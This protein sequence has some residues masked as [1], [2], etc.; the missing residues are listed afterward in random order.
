[1]CF[2]HKEGE[3]SRVCKLP[4]KV[5]TLEKGTIAEGMQKLLGVSDIQ[6]SRTVGQM[7]SQTPHPSQKLP[8]AAMGVSV[9]CNPYSCLA[10]AAVASKSYN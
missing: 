4:W 7:Q 8:L 3:S 9:S 1:M 10:F 6:S 5:V 2:Q